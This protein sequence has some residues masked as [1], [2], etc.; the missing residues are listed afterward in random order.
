MRHTP[1]VGTQLGSWVAKDD[2]TRPSLKGRKTNQKERNFND[3]YGQVSRTAGDSSCFVFMGMELCPGSN[4]L[5]RNSLRS[6][7]SFHARKS[8]G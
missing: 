5:R 3:L 2:S 8:Q 7:G 6:P 4:P 1:P